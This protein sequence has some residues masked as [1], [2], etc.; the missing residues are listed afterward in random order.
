MKISI[1][2]AQNNQRGRQFDMPALRL[3]IRTKVSSSTG[4]LFEFEK[5]SLKTILASKRIF[6]CF[7]QDLKM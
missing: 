2:A 7:Q 6:F 1:R 4:L 5:V 3:W